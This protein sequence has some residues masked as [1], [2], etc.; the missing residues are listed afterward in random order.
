MDCQRIIAIGGSAGA[1]GA[2]RTLC[3][4][5]SSEMP[6]AICIVIHVGAR[7][8]NL[9]ASALG[10]SC[11][12]PVETAVDGQR[13][14]NGRAYVAAADHHLVVVDGLIRLGHGPR[15]NLARPAIDPLLRSVGVTYGSRAVGVVLTGMLN[16]GAAGLADLKRCGGVTV[17][18][19]PTEA[20]ERDMPLAAL[21]ASGIDYRAPLAELGP[22]FKYLTSKPAPPSP[23]PPDDVR[24]EVDIALGL[25]AGTDA[26]SRLANPVPL[27]C[28]ACGGV[29][30]QV[31]RSPPLRFRCQVGHAY[32]A[33]ALASEQEGS[34]DEAM[35]VALRI[36]EERAVLTKKMADEAREGGL[37]LSA[38]S[39]ERTSAE[40]RGHVVTLREALLKSQEERSASSA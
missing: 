11:P 39:F 34:V 31:R 14:E 24:L 10:G 8:Q 25:P 21:A 3:G 38:A 28:P 4:G 7:G 18:Q 16:D 9:V 32:T 17:V 23:P 20:V 33:E 30:S 1:I 29:L 15:E 26:T 19:N 40:S 5:L 35:R 37:R 36:V 6:A 13:L 27:S 2:I 22:L 12:I